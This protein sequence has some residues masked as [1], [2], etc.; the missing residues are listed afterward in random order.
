MGRVSFASHF[1][2]PA[3]LVA[4]ALYLV[5]SPSVGAS[6]AWTPQAS[7]TTNNLYDVAALDTS[8]AWAVGDSS[9]VLKTTDGGST[10][11]S[12]PGGAEARFE[13]LAAVDTNTA[14][15]V[16]LQG[17]IRKTDNGGASW[18]TQSAFFNEPGS[19]LGASAR[20]R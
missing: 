2:L 12:Q 14:W 6:T 9:T 20:F 8:T 15:I 17:T 19:E 13:S 1:I 5:H 10:W 7:G 16:G 3:L 4:G 18:G 11:I